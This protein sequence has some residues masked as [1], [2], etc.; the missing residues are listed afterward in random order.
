M[1]RDILTRAYMRLIKHI[2]SIYKVCCFPLLPC[3]I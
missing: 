3:L 2:N 1:E